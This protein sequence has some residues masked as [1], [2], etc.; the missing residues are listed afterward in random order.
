MGADSFDRDCVE[1]V[2]NSV[3]CPKLEKFDRRRR[4]LFTVEQTLQQ[5]IESRLS[6]IR[7]RIRLFSSFVFPAEKARGRTRVIWFLRS[8]IPSSNGDS[9]IGCILPF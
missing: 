1:F 6:N 4:D 2:V 7:F 5:R 9:G 8:R 3:Q